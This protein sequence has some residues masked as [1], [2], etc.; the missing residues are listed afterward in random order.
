MKRGFDPFQ[1]MVEQGVLSMAGSNR[2]SNEADSPKERAAVGG[3]FKGLLSKIE[4]NWIELAAAALLA[5]ATIM[6]AY[7]A[8]Q[9]SKWSGT[10]SENFNKSDAALFESVELA[11]K[12]NYEIAV[13][14][15]MLSNYLNASM[16]GNTTLAQL[17]E[18]NA[19]SD[20]L[21]VAFTAWMEARAENKPNLP[22]SPFGM[23]EY[24]NA[25]QEQSSTLKLKARSESARAK[26]ATKHSNNYILL[27]VLFASVL[28]FAG[29]STKFEGKGT[30][31]AMLTMGIAIFVGS[32]VVLLLQP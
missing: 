17:Y 9:A 8:F 2:S 27:T 16:Q 29:I 15:E 3:R 21:K 30:K 6:S 1:E 5:L 13:D 26:T 24:K 28:F 19:F 23:P 4:H 31:L 11:D 14:V 22:K 20:A 32:V 7:S 10:S 18:S 25:N 12:A